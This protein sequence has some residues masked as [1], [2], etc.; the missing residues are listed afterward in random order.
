MLHSLKA[1]LDHLLDA[2]K[3]AKNLKREIRSKGAEKEAL[4]EELETI[5]GRS[6]RATDDDWNYDDVK[7]ST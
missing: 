6:G 4:A 3:D 7:P 5:K 1:V 2:K